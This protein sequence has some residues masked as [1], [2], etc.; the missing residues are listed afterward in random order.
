MKGITIFEI[1][2][3]LLVLAITIAA[4]IASG[5]TPDSQVLDVGPARPPE[6]GTEVGGILLI[7]VPSSELPDSVTDTMSF[8]DW[9]VECEYGGVTLQNPIRDVVPLS[10]IPPEELTS[11]E[12]EL[13]LPLLRQLQHASLVEFRINFGDDSYRTE[14]ALFAYQEPAD[15]WMDGCWLDYGFNVAHIAH[16]V[17]APVSGPLLYAVASQEVGLSEE[18][19]GPL[20]MITIC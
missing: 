18:P 17:T 9:Y 8:V 13:V 14:T 11:D 19:P 20:R 4:R 6:L 1:A 12:R 2:M 3:V 10:L 7:T 16:A 15:G 5:Q